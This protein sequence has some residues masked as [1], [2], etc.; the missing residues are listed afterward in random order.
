MGAMSRVNVTSVAAPGEDD[1]G[2][3]GVCAMAPMVATTGTANKAPA[4]THARGRRSFDITASSNTAR[5]PAPR[6]CPHATPVG[7]QVTRSKT[8]IRADRLGAAVRLATVQEFE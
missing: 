3:E 1:E 4:R 8:T 5:R 7:G 2:D 6:D